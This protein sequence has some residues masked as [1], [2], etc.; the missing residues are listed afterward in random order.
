MNF[1]TLKTI[2]LFILI[3]FSLF[4]TVALWNYQ[5]NH[6]TQDDDPIIENTKIE[7]GQTLTTSEVIVPKNIIFHTLSGDYSYKSPASKQQLYRQTQNFNLYNFETSETG[8]PDNHDMTE[9]VLPTEIPTKM[10]P[11]LFKVSDDE[12]VS[13]PTGNF[14]HILFILD[15]SNEAITEVLFISAD[16]EHTVRAQVQSTDAYQTMVQEHQSLD[17]KVEMLSY[18][19]EETRLYIPKKEVVLA[20]HDIS[21]SPVGTEPLLN[22]LFDD[23]SRVKSSIKSD[24][25]EIFSDF[26]SELRIAPDEKSV[27]LEKALTKEGLPLDTDEVISESLSF[28]NAHEGWTGDYHLSDISDQ[29][30]SYQMNYNGYP[31]LDKSNLSEI[32]VKYRQ[33]ELYIYQRPLIHIAVTYD[34][35]QEE[36][37]N[38]TLA[39][40][41]NILAELESSKQF[42]ARMIEDIRIGYS[43]VPSDNE[44]DDVYTMMPSWFIKYNGNWYNVDPDDENFSVLKGGN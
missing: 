44:Y 26:D 35:N 7:N 4:L 15:E 43:M 11:N 42:N 19:R 30:V 28:I 18:Q 2:I 20:R 38:V 8:F 34:T 13:I 41:E 31:I 27:K 25:T 3:M 33:E 22:T 29:Q 12:K 40:G 37:G 5:P 17:N 24:G 23:V 32:M 39:S 1:E 16:G 14:K 6:E 21:V 9:F 36:G 10:I